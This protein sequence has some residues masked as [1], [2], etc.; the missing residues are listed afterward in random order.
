MKKLLG[1]IF[2]ATPGMSKTMITKKLEFE[3][4]TV[5]ITLDD[6]HIF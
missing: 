5:R 2:S 1:I 3:L 4:K 6:G